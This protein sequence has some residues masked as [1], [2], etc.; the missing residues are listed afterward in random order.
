[1]TRIELE[2]VVEASKK[3]C[4]DLSRSIDLHL[5]S[6]AD[7]KEKAIAGKTSGLIGQGEWVKWKAVHFFTEQTMTVK[8]KSMVHWNY[9]E[10]V[11]TNG[12]FKKMR[13]VHWFQANG[14]STIM[15][16]IFEYEV[17]FGFLGRLFDRLILR[18]YMT[19]LLVHRNN[20]IKRTAESDRWKKF[21]GD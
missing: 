2:T 15:Q 7:T 8:I 21:I 17:P 1:M 10:D 12:P 5:L 14:K 6:T 3:I 16:D 18:R 20:V 11:M 19:D 13:H 9:F 4:F